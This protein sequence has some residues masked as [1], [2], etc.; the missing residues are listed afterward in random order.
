[1]NIKQ[2]IG[3]VVFSTLLITSCDDDDNTMVVNENPVVSLDLTDLPTIEFMMRSLFLV[4]LHL[5][6]QFEIFLFIW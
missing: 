2:I 3:A 1:M 6:M 5:L 4:Q